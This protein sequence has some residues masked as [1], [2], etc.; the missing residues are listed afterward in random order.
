MSLGRHFG[1]MS[2]LRV[3]IARK[4]LYSY[5]DT[6]VICG[7]PVLSELDGLGKTFTNPRLV[8]E[9]LSPSTERYDRTRKF[10]RYREL[11]A[12]QEYVLVEQ[13]APR[14][15][16]RYRH[17]DGTWRLDF[18]LGLESTIVLPSLSISIPLA[19]I[20]SA[21]EFPLSPEDSDDKRDEK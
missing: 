1:S 21:M 14:A 12:F 4:K 9:I 18:A 2:N 15:E 8:V 13:D 17:P 16:T 6:A 5:T 10:D 20:Y 7:Q 3:Q 19:E 11:E